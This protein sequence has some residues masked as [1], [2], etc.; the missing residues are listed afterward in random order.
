MARAWPTAPTIPPNWL[1]LAT[2]IRNQY[3][4]IQLLPNL[5]CRGPGTSFRPSMV[6]RPLTIE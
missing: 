6:V 4:T 2:N 1:I 3:Q 5:G